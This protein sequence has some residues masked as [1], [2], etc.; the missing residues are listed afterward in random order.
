MPKI[1][2][3]AD[4]HGRY[5]AEKFLAM[6]YEVDAVFKPNAVHEQVMDLGNIHE[7]AIL[8]L[9]AGTNNTWNLSGESEN[10][11]SIQ[12]VL[13]NLDF[14]KI[15]NTNRKIIYVEIPKRFNTQDCEAVNRAIH[16][17]NG[18]I[19]NIL[20]KNPN[21]RIIKNDWVTSKLIAEDKVHFNRRG[22]EM[23]VH[24][25]RQIIDHF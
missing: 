10:Q 17:L 4:S 1:S 5:L 18:K 16:K 3:R 8:I 20:H 14:S 11:E 13:S 21:I 24:K 22:K 6:G 25:I 2:I 7:N 19:F 9:I 23:L 15:K 12:T